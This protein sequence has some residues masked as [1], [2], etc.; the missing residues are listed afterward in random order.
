MG[1]VSL[2]KEEKKPKL[3]LPLSTQSRCHVSIREMTAIYKPGEEPSPRNKSDDT[4]ISD[5]PASGTM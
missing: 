4:L 1:L 3:F 2:E 5:F